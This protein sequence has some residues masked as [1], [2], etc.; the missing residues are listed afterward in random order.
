MQNNQDQIETAVQNRLYSLYVLESLNKKIKAISPCMGFIIKGHNNRDKPFFTIIFTVEGQLKKVH[1]A[2]TIVQRAP[3]IP[4]W[5]FQALVQPISD[6]E[7]IKTGQDHPFQFPDI[8]LK[9]S[10]MYFNMLDYDMHKKTMSIT[11]CCPD[12][13]NLFDNPYIQ[14]GVEEIL[15]FLLGEIAFRNS[16]SEIQ[17]E[18]IPEEID[19]LSPLYELPQYIQ[20]LKN[21]NRKMKI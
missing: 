5:K 15:M 11:V 12:H 21:L 9:I 8:E 10:D 6:L 20:L 14:E 18:P 2:T 4:S 7:Q 1:W 3:S 13:V 16:V 17:V 19:E